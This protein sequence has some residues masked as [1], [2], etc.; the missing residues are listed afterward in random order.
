[1]KKIEKLEKQGTLVF[2][3]THFPNDGAFIIF[4]A[5]DE[6]IP[7]DFVKNVRRICQNFTLY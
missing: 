5:K 1:M 3:G 4:N 6:T 2:G 7:H